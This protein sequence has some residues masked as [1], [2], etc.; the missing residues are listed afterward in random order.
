[1]MVQRTL[2]AKN[3][4]DA[5]KAYLLMGYLAFFI[6]FFYIVLGI[7][8][9][10]YYGGREFEN[11]NTIILEFA[12]EYGMPGLMGIIAAAVIPAR[13]TFSTASMTFLSLG[14]SAPS[15]TVRS[16]RPT[17]RQS[18][19]AMLQI[20]SIASTACESSICAIT[21]VSSLLLCKFSWYSP[22]LVKTR[23]SRAPLRG[24]ALRLQCTQL[25]RH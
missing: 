25:V 22:P 12:A 6:Y 7:L 15:A 19:P 20:S 14:E 16:L 23:H 21:V 17:K 11:G 8:F 4:G 13:Q 2:A 18:I 9:Y 10:S 1:M 3:I 24:S 5:K